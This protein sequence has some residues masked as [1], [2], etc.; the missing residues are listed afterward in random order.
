MQAAER[1]N[2]RAGALAE[3]A[4]VRDTAERLANGDYPEQ[5]D[6]V[7]VLAG[8]IGQPRGAGRTHGARG[9]RRRLER[10]DARGRRDPR[11]GPGGAAGRPGE[12]TERACMECTQLGITTGEAP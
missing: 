9:R 3:V 1:T 7:R 8:L 4:K 12:L 11:Q 10:R 5:A 6:H 2:E